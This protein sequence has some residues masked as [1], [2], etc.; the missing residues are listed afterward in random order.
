MA[1]GTV[2]AG[3]DVE[4]LERFREGLEQEQVWLGLEARALWEGKMGHSTVHI[5]PYE[6]GG[7]R[8]ER[9]TRHYTIPYGAWREVE[10]AVGAVGPVD[11]QEPVEMAL[12][13]LAAC[14]V[15]SISYNA[16]REGIE[17]DDLQ[18]KVSTQAAPDVLFALRG[19]EQHPACMQAIRA[20]VTAT[21]P[22]L[23]PDKLEKIKTLAEHSPVHGLL[24]FPNEIATTV[25]AAAGD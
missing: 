5:G 22:N 15:V 1:E 12:G 6:L 19:P 21:G 16:H 25:R 13:A 9:E 11:R 23:T 18:V 3:V 10:A 7:E 4:K 20:E 2:V 8:I 14:L 17:L 24:S